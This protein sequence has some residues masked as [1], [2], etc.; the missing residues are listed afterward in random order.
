MRQV[1]LLRDRMIIKE[2]QQIAFIKKSGSPFS[3][4][5]VSAFSHRQN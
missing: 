4:Q 1:Y 2:T 3:P 5:A